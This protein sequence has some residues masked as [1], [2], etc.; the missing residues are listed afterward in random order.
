VGHHVVSDQDKEKSPGEDADIKVGDV[1]LEIN[2]KSVKKMKDVKPHVE[3]AG[4]DDKPLDVTI[5]RGEETIERKLH[6][7]YDQKDDKY[8]IGLY[9]RDSAAG[10]GTMSFYEPNSKKYGALGHV[11][12]A[13]DPKNQL[14]IHH[15]TIVRSS[16]TSIAKDKNG[17]ITKNSPFGIFGKLE[18]PIKNNKYDEP[19]PIALSHEVK[20]GPAKILTVVEGEKVEE[21]DVE[22]VSSVPQKFPATKGMVVKIND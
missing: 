13:M 7:I 22:I 21:F 19:M 8:Q 12:S 17:S 14:D 3:K 10:I 4:E 1:I 5:K 18:E 11:I 9:I 16:L 15:G 2:G 6:P 20:E